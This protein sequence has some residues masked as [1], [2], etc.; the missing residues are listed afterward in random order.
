MLPTVQVITM[1]EQEFNNFC[2]KVSGEILDIL[3]SYE[4]VGIPQALLLGPLV[5]TTV[6]FSKML[7]IPIENLHSAINSADDD[8]ENVDTYD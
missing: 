2:N 7:G 6:V 4:D 3:E 8:I 5:A 1:T